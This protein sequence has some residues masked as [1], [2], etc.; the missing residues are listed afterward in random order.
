MSRDTLVRNV[1]L[2]PIT[3]EGEGNLSPL[4]ESP[5]HWLTMNFCAE[6]KVLAYN[7]NEL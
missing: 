5:L 2:P 4:S 1:V 6:R 7:A 3:R